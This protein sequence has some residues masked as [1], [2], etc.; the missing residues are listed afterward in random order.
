MVDG[1]RP[2]G[3]HHLV[4]S[5]GRVPWAGHESTNEVSAS[6]PPQYGLLWFFNRLIGSLKVSKA[7]FV[8]QAQRSNR[9]TQDS[10][11]ALVTV[12]HRWSPLVTVGH[13]WRPL[14]TK[15]G[16]LSNTA[17]GIEPRQIP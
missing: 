6:A 13:R 1:E 17:F 10:R 16:S 3:M 11:P 8:R 15:K 4:Q 7:F 14:V 5:A 9:S 12:G 2:S